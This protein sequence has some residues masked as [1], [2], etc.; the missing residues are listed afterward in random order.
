M[1]ARRA[2]VKVS[3]QLVTTHFR[4]L[5]EEI[6]GSDG[7]KFNSI[8]KHGKFLEFFDSGEN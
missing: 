2:K 8:V 4:Q 5:N 3:V 1:Q 6:S 7:P